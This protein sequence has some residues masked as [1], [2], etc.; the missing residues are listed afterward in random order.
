LQQ[1]PPTQ[2]PLRQSS[3]VEQGPVGVARAQVLGEEALEA[4]EVGGAAEELAVLVAVAR[5][6]HHVLGAPHD[7]ERRAARV[8]AAGA[9]G[10]LRAAEGVLRGVAAAGEVASAVAVADL[11]DRGV[12][13]EL[14][15]AAAVAVL[16]M[17][18]TPGYLVMP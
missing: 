6:A 12:D 14:V 7:Q 13:I 3:A 9:A 10:A 5:R 16:R 1:T 15:P 2:K 4:G 8:A 17:Q 11:G 18:L